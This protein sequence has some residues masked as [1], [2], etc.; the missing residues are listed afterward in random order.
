VELYEPYLD[1]CKM[2]ELI[3]TIDEIA[4]YGLQPNLIEVDKKNIIS[5]KFGENL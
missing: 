3:P 1:N 2:K 4:K 5:K